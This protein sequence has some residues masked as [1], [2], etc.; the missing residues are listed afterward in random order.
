MM[1][2]ETCCHEYTQF[3]F[4]TLR[5]LCEHVYLDSLAQKQNYSFSKSDKPG[6]RLDLHQP[7]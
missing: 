3:D 5:N 1:K 6:S 2:C 4:V 7:V